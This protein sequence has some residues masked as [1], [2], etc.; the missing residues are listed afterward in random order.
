M[1]DTKLFQKSDW[2]QSLYLLP[3]IIFVLLFSLRESE[4]YAHIFDFLPV[5]GRT[6]PFFC[7]SVFLVSVF[8]YRGGHLAQLGLCWPS[9]DKTKWQ[10]F[11]WIVLW[12]IGILALRIFIAVAS[13]PMLESL[14]QSVSRNNSL[15]NNLA[16]LISLLPIMWLIV[17]GEEV[18]I[19][20]LLMNYI[21]KMFGSTAQGWLLS[22]LISSV[23]FGLAHLGKGPV[24]AIGSGLAGVAF[25]LGYFLSGKNL[26][27]VVLAH[28]TGNTI[29]FVGAYF[30]D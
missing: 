23:I 12:A 6:I 17:I 21:A 4:T 8:K 24:A 15:N 13:E 29:G 18:L 28:C 3:F 2:G 11:T 25:G 16:L 9:R 27:P 19:R 22:I 5:L 1:L 10:I 14:P 7:L 26:W 20:G 30:N